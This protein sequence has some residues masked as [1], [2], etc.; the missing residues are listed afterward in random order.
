ML[1]KPKTLPSR[2]VD[3]NRNWALKW[4]PDSVFASADTNPGP[5]AFSEPETQIFRDT[6][7]DFAP[8]AFLTIHSGTKG[9]ELY[10]GS[11]RGRKVR[12]NIV[13]GSTRERK[14]RIDIL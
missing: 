8:N 2:G 3:L 11:T 1:P 4:E 7:T 13:C 10:C 14:V 6:V 5:S 12:N 9:E